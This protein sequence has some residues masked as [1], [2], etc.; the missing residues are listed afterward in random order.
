MP[1]D[2]HSLQIAGIVQE[3]RDT[4]SFV[5]DVPKS[6]RETFRYRAGQF[7]TFEVPWNGMQLRRCYSL[8]SAP[9]TDPWPK[10]T[11]KRVEDGRISN[12]FNDEL[13]VGDTIL[14][15]PPE[16]RFVLRSNEGDHGIV[17]F[18]GG[19]GITPVLSIMKS[20]LRTTDRDVKL[21][22]ANRD[23]HSIIFKDEIDL[24]L[25]ELPN[26]LEVFHHLDTEHG[27]MTVAQI[28]SHFHGWEDAEFF[29]CGPTGYMDAI[30][31]A[32]KASNIDIG[33]TKFER[34]ISLAD[35]DRK[36]EAATALPEQ[37]ADEIPAS[38]TMLLEGASHEVPYEKGLTLLG[39]AVKAGHKPP[40]S[41]EDGYCGCCMAL[42]KSGRVDMANHDAL[43][44]SDIERGWVLACQARPASQEPIEIDFD[45]EY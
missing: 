3:T 9:E 2:F 10:V 6:L 4:R 42:L 8:S 21:I 23:E 43:E 5:L 11:V 44:P 7:L 18:G 26:R 27:F 14:V 36:D 45:A 17:L 13:R 20:A 19:S 39:S 28:Q 35:P 30:E 41:C 31:E 40:S 24:W 32:F 33:Q 12:W 34:F 1:A 37:S 22:Y 15:Q 38:F 25:R 16:G 29:V